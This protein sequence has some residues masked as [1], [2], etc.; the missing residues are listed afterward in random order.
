MT[1]IM[2]RT[3]LMQYLSGA[4]FSGNKEHI[5]SHYINSPRIL[6]QNNCLL[7]VVFQMTQVLAA[8]HVKYNEKCSFY[9]GTQEDILSN[10]VKITK[11]Q[12]FIVDMLTK[13]RQRGYNGLGCKIG[14]KLLK[15]Y[16]NKDFE[17]SS[18]KLAI[19]L[20]DYYIM[21]YYHD[22]PSSLEIAKLYV[23]I[24]RRDFQF[25]DEFKRNEQLI[26]SNFSFLPIDVFHT[27]TQI[28]PICDIPIGN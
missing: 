17:L 3:E 7:T 21:A 26:R 15:G 20:H 5:L 19:F 8:F 2:T 6:F 12:D 9:Y 28:N 14:K 11:S 4:L 27:D 18:G 23:D 13:C 22:K 16:L 10:Y 25:Y 24:Y 1:N